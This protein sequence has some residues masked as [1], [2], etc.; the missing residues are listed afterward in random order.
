M[1]LEAVASHDLWIWHAYFGCPGSMNDINVLHQSHLFKNL[2]NGHAPSCNFTIA[3]NAYDMG[4]YLADGIYPEWGTLVKTIAEPVS[5]KEIHFAKQQEAARKD[6]E[7]AFGVLQSRFAVVSNPVKLWKP[8]AL[9]NVM[10]TCVI[11]HN[12][13]IEEERGEFPSYLGYDP[14][15]PSTIRGERWERE[16]ATIESFLTR[17]RRIRSR[18]IH[19]NLQADLIEHLWHFKGNHIGPD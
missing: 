18:E 12:M 14:D 7:R 13:I 10:K 3:G 6:V 8:Q 17:M 5:A 1:I 15:D 2:A 19:H 9:N 11:L 16:P 4:Y